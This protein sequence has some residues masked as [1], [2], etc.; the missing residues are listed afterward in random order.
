M[1]NSIRQSTQESN[2]YLREIKQVSDCNASVTSGNN[3]N[4]FSDSDSR[5]TSLIRNRPPPP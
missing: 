4:R 5:S 3:Q 2:H 1:V